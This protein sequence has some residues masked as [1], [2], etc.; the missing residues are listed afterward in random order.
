MSESSRPPEALVERVQVDEGVELSTA[1]IA[2]LYRIRSGTHRPANSITEGVNKIETPETLYKYLHQVEREGGP[3]V[4]TT[5]TR[6]SEWQQL[7][8]QSRWANV[9]YLHSTRLQLLEKLLKHEQ[10][11]GKFN[12]RALRMERVQN[13]IKKLSI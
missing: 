4:L 13:T 10:H 1:D 2:L 3:S 12:G 9:A 11:S 7:Y 8:Q 5:L 6:D